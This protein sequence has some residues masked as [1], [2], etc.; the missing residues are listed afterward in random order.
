MLD[1]IYEWGSHKSSDHSVPYGYRD[2]YEAFLSAGS[3]EAVARRYKADQLPTWRK[4]VDNPTYNAFWRGQAV[5]DILATRPL[6]VPTL[7]VHG[8][9]DQE[10]NFGGIAAYRSLEAMDAG[11][12]RVHL[13][14]GEDQPFVFVYDVDNSNRLV[15]R[16]IFCSDFVI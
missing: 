8:L 5:Q 10:D 7:V 6:R 1:W 2:L 3:A 9:F 12:T 15:H 11:N 13:A 4:V 14:V 16:G